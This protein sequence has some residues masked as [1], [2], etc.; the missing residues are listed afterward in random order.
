MARKSREA[1]A[2]V[3]LSK[4][5]AGERLPEIIDDLLARRRDGKDEE[6]VPSSA[7]VAAEP[8]RAKSSEG[9]PQSG[10]PSSQGNARVSAPPPRRGG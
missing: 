1:G 10:G 9:G 2:D 5:I 8:G 3:F 7:V 4:P 6:P